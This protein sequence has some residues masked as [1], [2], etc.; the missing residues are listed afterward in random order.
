MEAD[1]HQRAFKLLEL[2]RPADALALML[3]ALALDPQD[4]GAAYLAAHAQ[5]RLGRPK[6]A[7]AFARQA[8]AG[9]PANA[10]YHR[11]LAHTWWAQHEP[12]RGLE[13]I[14]EAVRLDPN[15]AESHYVRGALL[16]EL[17][18]KPEALEALGQAVRLHPEHDRAIALRAY[19]VSTVHGPARGRTLLRSALQLDPWNAH[20]LAKQAWLA[21]VH[22]HP[23]DHRAA[24][25]A[26]LQ[27]EPDNAL[28]GR[29][30]FLASLPFWRLQARR[31]LYAM[32]VEED[33]QVGMRFILTFCFLGG[34]VVLAASKGHPDV[35]VMLG[36]ISVIV[37]MFFKET[38][39]CLVQAW[40]HFFS[41]ERHLIP[42]RERVIIQCCAGLLVLGG[43]W[44]LLATQHVGLRAMP[45][46]LAAQVGSMLLHMRFEP[47][48]RVRTQRR[49]A[50]V[51]VCLMAGALV[52][53]GE[54]PWT[55][56][57]SVVALLMALG[58]SRWLAWTRDH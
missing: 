20:T 12:R 56:L 40:G 18:H 5:L 50:Y 11:T 38:L 1:H 17:G 42:K 45:G 41:R 35:A 52:Y 34:I 29:G 19:I 39:P 2:H 21:F 30:L 43:A 31:E 32:G 14:D 47:P 33:E 7:M 13:H 51:G 4:H 26:V 28:A 53:F 9:A 25:R 54:P 24:F 55:H 22:E 23:V 37:P 57:P 27:V 36:C 8:V 3:E 44:T 6:E 58:W 46:M 49:L 16:L 10:A 48:Q 15:D